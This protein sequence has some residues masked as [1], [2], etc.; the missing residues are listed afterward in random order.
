LSP[1]HAEASGS[2]K[3]ALRPQVLDSANVNAVLGR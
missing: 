2:L 3:N 1:S